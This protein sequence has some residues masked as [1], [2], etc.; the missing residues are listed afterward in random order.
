MV[1]DIDYVR[2][3]MEVDVTYRVW[4]PTAYTGYPAYDG[5]TNGYDAQTGARS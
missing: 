1:K 5:P 2:D 3:T 4:A